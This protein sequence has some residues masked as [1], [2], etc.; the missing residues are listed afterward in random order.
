M[1]RLRGN[2]PIL[3]LNREICASY[4][5]TLQVTPMVMSGSHFFLSSKT[6][7]IEEEEA[8]KTKGSCFDYVVSQPP[9]TTERR[10]FNL[11]FSH[12]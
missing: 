5:D 12:Q 9:S 6:L 4:F 2:E 1:P 7:I 3:G 10:E 11:C 8:I